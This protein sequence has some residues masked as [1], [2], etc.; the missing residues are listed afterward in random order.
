[1]KQIKDIKKKLEYEDYYDPAFDWKDWYFYQNNVL[2]ESFIRE[3]KDKVYWSYISECQKLSED[4]KK[5]YCKKF[6]N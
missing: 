2:S 3:F 4:F 6:K 1:M 5:E